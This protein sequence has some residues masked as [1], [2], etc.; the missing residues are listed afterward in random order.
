MSQIVQHESKWYFIN[1][2]HR[3][4]LHEL[5]Q[6]KKILDEI[7]AQEIFRKVLL[8]VAACHCLGIMIR[9]IKLRKFAFDERNELA[10]IAQQFPD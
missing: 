10:I 9:E 2:P 8:I 5:I 6:R 7:E 1:P 3:E 4:T